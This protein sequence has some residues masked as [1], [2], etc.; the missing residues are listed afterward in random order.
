MSIEISEEGGVRYL[1]FGSRW[2]QGAMRIARPFALELEYTRA[3]LFPLLLHEGAGWPRRVLLV[4]LGAG[5]LLKFLH[6]HRRAALLDVVEIDARVVTAAGQFFHL[7]DDPARIDIEVGDGAAT[8]ARPGPACDLVLVDGYDARGRVGALDTE[9]FYRQAR[10]RLTRGGVLA[11]NLLTRGGGVGPSVERLRAA[12]GS[13]VRSLPPCTSGNVI[14]VASRG[15]LP[16][17]PFPDL[18]AR[19][20][21]LRARTGL[22][23]LPL[24]AAVAADQ[25]GTAFIL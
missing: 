5:S 14:V 3:M 4:G 20:R 22:N 24:V 17:V 16:P 25:G 11:T 18:R 2:V 12:F 10:F 6:R 19:A 7:P 23:L 8:V 9:T 1:H 15:G 13:H 21:G